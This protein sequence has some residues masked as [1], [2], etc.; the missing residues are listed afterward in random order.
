MPVT[1]RTQLLITA[2]GLAV[3][4]PLQTDAQQ[5]STSLSPAALAEI[6]Q[7]EAAIDRIE[8]CNARADCKPA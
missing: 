8:D 5:A 1:R 7:V 2:I 6:A 3:L 4:G